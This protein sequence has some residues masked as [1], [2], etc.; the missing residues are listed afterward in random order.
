MVKKIEVTE[1]KLKRGFTTI[2]YLHND[3]GD[4]KGFQAYFETFL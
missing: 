2:F 1:G 4:L 3:K